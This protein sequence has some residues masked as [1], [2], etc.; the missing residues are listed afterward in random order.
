L[1]GKRPLYS[2]QGDACSPNETTQSLFS[3]R[4][5]IRL[6]SRLNTFRA[7]VIVASRFVKTKSSKCVRPRLRI[8]CGEEIALG[9]GKIDLLAIISETGSIR[10]AAEAMNMSY[11]R[12]WTLIRTMNA[13]FKTPLVEALRGGKE[14]GGARLTRTGS[15]VFA[16]Y[17]RMEESSLK[18]IESDW[19]EIKRLLR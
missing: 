8:Q 18:V 14:G 17:R 5:L 1:A 13:C 7:F 12:A 2:L 3:A 10:K 4:I 19:D 16:L 6:S 15:R 11:M 9:P